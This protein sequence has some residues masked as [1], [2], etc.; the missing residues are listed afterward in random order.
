MLS[1]DENPLTIEKVTPF[2][3]KDYINHLRALDSTFRIRCLRYQNI[4]I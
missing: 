1:Y 4:K 3:Q 2:L